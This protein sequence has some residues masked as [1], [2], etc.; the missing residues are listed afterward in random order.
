MQIRLFTRRANEYTHIYAPC[1]ED[2]IVANIAAENVI[3]DGEIL[4]YDRGGLGY[5]KG[6]IPFGNNRSVAAEEIEWR[7]KNPGSSENP[8]R[9]MFY[10]VFDLLHVSGGDAEA[11]AMD[12]AGKDLRALEGDVTQWPLEHRRKLLKRILTEVP[13]RL[14]VV[15]QGPVMHAGGS[16]EKRVRAI[17]AYFQKAVDNGEEGLVV[18]DLQSKYII[19]EKSRSAAH[20]VKMK[21]EYSDQTAHID[22][23]IVAA[24]YG[25]GTRRSGLLSHFL[26]AVCDHHTMGTSSG[27]E[28]VDVN[29]TRWLTF[30]KVG[31][32][33][34][35]NELQVLND[36]LKPHAIPYV[37]EKDKAKSGSSASSV[38]PKW[39][40]NWSHKIDDVPDVWIPPDK[41]Y[42]LEIKCAELCRTDQFTAPYTPRFP[43]C[44]NIRYDKAWWQSISVKELNELL[45][46][47]GNKHPISGDGDEATLRGAATRAARKKAKK[48]GRGGRDGK[49]KGFEVMGGVVSKQEA[50]KEFKLSKP[51]SDLFDDITFCVAHFEGTKNFPL[52]PGKEDEAAADVGISQVLASQSQIA[53]TQ[54]QDDASGDGTGPTKKEKRKKLKARLKK[55]SV[56]DIQKLLWVYGAKEVWA[57]PSM[58]NS[59]VDV[60]LTH[61][62]GTAKTQNF[63][64]GVYKRK[65]VQAA[66]R[67]KEPPKQKSKKRRAG[68]TD[69]DDDDDDDDS[70]DDDGEDSEEDCT[71]VLSIAW[72]LDCVM[73]DD[74]VE[75]EFEHIIHPS[76]QTVKGARLFSDQ[77]GDRYEEPTTVASLK[78]AFAVMESV[79]DKFEKYTGK[80]QQ[81]HRQPHG[82]GAS[83]QS[84]SSQ[85]SQFAWSSS[86]QSS[87]SQL[88][89]PPASGLLSS[90]ASLGSSSSPFANVLDPDRPLL[91]PWRQATKNDAGCVPD[92]AFDRDVFVTRFH[93]GFAPR[94]LPLNRFAFGVG[95]GDQALGFMS[96]GA[97]NDFRG[98]GGGGGGGSGSGGGSGG[99]QQQRGRRSLFEEEP[100]P[101][102]PLP[103]LVSWQSDCSAR[104][105]Y[106]DQDAMETKFTV[107]RRPDVV[108][109]VD[110]HS[111]IGPPEP[112]RPAA[113][114]AVCDDLA[115]QSPH[116][117]PAF[118]QA[119]SSLSDSHPTL[120]PCS[121][122]CAV[123]FQL[124]LHS[125]HVADCLH[126][127]VTHV[128]VEDPRSNSTPLSSKE[129]LGAI[130]R[131][132]QELR[133]HEHRFYEQRLV[134]KQWVAG[135]LA[136]GLVRPPERSA[137][138]VELPVLADFVKEQEKM[139]ALAEASAKS[140]DKMDTESADDSESGAT[141]VTTSAA[142]VTTETSAKA[143][144]DTAAVKQKKKKKKKRKKQYFFESS[145]SDS[146]SD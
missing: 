28:P 117:S 54:T 74:M 57:N 92:R 39:L 45:S 118:H 134:T 3:L 13:N 140:S 32:G 4:A 70:D 120:L 87:M 18:K 107:F 84:S 78:R 143:D 16:K 27:E 67:A 51:V 127:G 126:S 10:V 53:V 99:G 139:A 69:D 123:R 138:R 91:L 121:S 42:I 104:L 115:K 12:L 62:A 7:K 15:K 43:R 31:T 142:K 96:D 80:K 48:R 129:R 20:W 106:E 125:A 34:D 30:G 50:L 75:A 81:Q 76:V 89:P 65:L 98:G 111:D 19:G 25:D 97:V 11:H 132:M 22:C 102:Q 103:T 108:I 68:N 59:H 83:S 135:C 17:Q 26:L 112:P 64:K 46:G 133:F 33:Y 93:A 100:P 14:E 95:S 110:C 86:S 37:R 144:A 52:L 55:Y 41:S 146:D 124:L 9:T 61:S 5:N 40:Q 82:R 36:K 56:A 71:D 131:R 23:L 85:C 109:Y 58:T 49:N 94:P 60:Y 38:W 35:I 72:F 1:L 113:D 66:R 77:F 136:D 130:H 47:G 101:E 44:V 2:L 145:D 8:R 105:Q 63:V 90:S 79:T 88:T 137:E 141:K 29:A 6:L 128:V 122:L 73:K 114:A 119:Q 24:Y 116:N 21:P